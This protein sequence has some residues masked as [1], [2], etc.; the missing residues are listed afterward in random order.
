MKAKLQT[1]E[2]Q[3]TQEVELPKQFEEEIRDDLIK[4]AVLAIQSHNMQAEGVNPEAG[5]RA[6]AQLSKRRRK[7]RGIYGRGESRTPRKV[8]SRSGTQF[9]YTGAFAPQTVGGRKAHPSKS[10]KIPA[11]KINKKEKQKAIRSAIAATADLELVKARGHKTDSA[12]IIVEDKIEELKKTVD[13]KKALKAIKLDKELER[14]KEKK[15]R[16]GKGKVRGRPYKKKKGPLL[17]VSKKCDL[18]KSAVNIPGVDIINVK[19][20][21]TEALA[22]G[23]QPGRLTIY[24]KSAIEIMDKEKLFK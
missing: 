13:V 4:R 15:V 24:T 22:P 17:V 18:V 1:L 16:A 12:P 5:K 19:E 6:S 9:N 14:T 8:M 2:G 20:L 7:Y 10:E 3:S 23:T 21:N 11:L